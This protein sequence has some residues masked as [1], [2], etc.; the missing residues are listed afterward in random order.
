MSSA[1]ADGYLQASKM[2]NAGKKASRRLPS[3]TQKGAAETAITDADLQKTYEKMAATFLERGIDANFVNSVRKYFSAGS[4]MSHGQ[5]AQPYS[6]LDGG[7]PPN[8]VRLLVLPV[9][10]QISSYGTSNLDRP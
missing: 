7:L 4:T 9:S 2:S 3:A 5:E 8:G 6:Q 10:P 1:E